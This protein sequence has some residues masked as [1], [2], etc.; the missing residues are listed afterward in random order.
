MSFCVFSLPTSH[1]QRDVCNLWLHQKNGQT[2]RGQSISDQDIL[3]RSNQR[4]FLPGMWE[5]INNGTEIWMWLSQYV[6]QM[7]IA[8]LKT[9][10]TYCQ[11][12]QNK[13]KSD[14]LKDVFRTQGV[15]G[16]LALPLN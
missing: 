2:G 4:P 9:G 5:I 1:F 15:M 8:F 10:F 13:S 14:G 12:K 6:L 3:A 11:D 7:E 16:R